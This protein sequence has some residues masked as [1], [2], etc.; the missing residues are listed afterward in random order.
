M[1]RA[2]LEYKPI[3]GVTLTGLISTRLSKT[4]RQHNVMD[5]SNQANAY[6]AGTDAQDDNS[7]VR[8]SNPLLYTDPDNELAIPE[9]VLPQ[10]GIK[11]Q[12]DDKMRSNNYRFMAEYRD[13]YNEK[14]VVNVLLGSELSTVRRTSTTWTGWGYQYNN[15]GIVY[16]PYLWLKQRNEEN[17]D[18][19]SEKYH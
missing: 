15:G 12:Y 19:F 3:K 10:G 9:S 16:T 8:Y 11:Y 1:F 13:V 5:N 14:H 7:T 18:Y 2:E 17:T 4:T 6:R